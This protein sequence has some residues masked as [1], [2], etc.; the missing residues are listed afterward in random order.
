MTYWVDEDRHG[1]T[2]APEWKEVM[3]HQRSRAARPAG[4]GFRGVSSPTRWRRSS[5]SQKR[6]GSSSKTKTSG[7]CG[8]GFSGRADPPHGGGIQGEG[9]MSDR[10][11]GGVGIALAIFYAW[12]TLQIEESFLSDAVGPKTFPARHR[13]DPRARVEPRDPAQARR[14]TRMADFGRL[15]EILA[16]V[17]VMVIY[18]EFLDVV[19][20]RHRHHLRHNLS[21]LA[22]RH[23]APRSFV[24]GV[25]HRGRDL[26]DLPSHPGPFAG[27]AAPRDSEGSAHGSPCKSRRRLQHRAHLPESGAGAAR[28]FLGTMMGALPGLGPSPTGSR[29]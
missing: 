25:L 27:A 8:R 14:R 4:R 16:A 13:G 21:Y 7:D 10:I 24:V 26:R 22:A 11:F 15:A 6:S 29:S 2:T 19:G 12:A 28:H 20:F 3:A 23:A 9:Q 17:V 5:R 1:S 18:A